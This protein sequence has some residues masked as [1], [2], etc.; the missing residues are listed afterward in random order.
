MEW[1]L[2]FKNHDVVSRTLESYIFRAR[3]HVL[4]TGKIPVIKVQ[5]IDIQKVL[6]GISHFS[7]DYRIKYIKIITCFSDML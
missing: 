6:N 7:L 3:N 1:L 2:N 5:S 4:K